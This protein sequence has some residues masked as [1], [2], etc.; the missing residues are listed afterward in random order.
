MW[1]VMT[2]R[3]ILIYF[4]LSDGQNPGMLVVPIVPTTSSVV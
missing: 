3:F 2:V 1:S 4:I